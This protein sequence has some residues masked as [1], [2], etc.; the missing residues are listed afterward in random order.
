MILAYQGNNSKRHLIVRFRKVLMVRQLKH[1][2]LY[3]SEIWQ[4]RVSAAETPA[5]RTVFDGQRS[6]DPADAWGDY[7]ATITSK[8]HFD[9][10]MAL[11]LPHLS[12][13]VVMSLWRQNNCVII[14]VEDGACV[15][16]RS[17]KYHHVWQIEAETKWP[18][19]K[20]YDIFTSILLNDHSCIFFFEICNGFVPNRRIN[21]LYRRSRASELKFT[22]VIHVS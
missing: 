16:Y 7:N 14:V 13:G 17:T 1:L 11:S 12:A 9:V 5:Y 8:R 21:Y 20:A 22:T 10:I 4:A 2:L 6:R 18:F 15:P 19:F 3:C